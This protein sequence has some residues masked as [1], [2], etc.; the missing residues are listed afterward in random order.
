V[1]IVGLMSAVSPVINNTPFIFFYWLAIAFVVNYG[2]Q[3]VAYVILGKQR[4]KM[5][6]LGIRLLLAIETFLCSWWH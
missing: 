1:V 6:G 5:T 2:L 4:L 3:F